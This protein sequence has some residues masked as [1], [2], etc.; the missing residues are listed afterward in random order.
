MTAPAAFVET[1]DTDDAFPGQPP[2]P[3]TTA[4]FVILLAAV[5]AASIVLFSYLYLSVPTKQTLFMERLTTCSIRVPDDATLPQYAEAAAQE[6]VCMRSAR[7]DQAAWVGAALGGELALAYGLYLVW[8]AW[9]RR[10]RGLVTFDGCTEIEQHLAKLTKAAE[11]DPAPTWL[12]DPGS[13]LASGYVFGARRRYSVCLRAGLITRFV[14]DRAAFDAVV[15]HELAHLRNRDVSKTHLT[16]TLWRTFVV[17]AALPVVALTIGSG[18]LTHP[19]EWFSGSATALPRIMAL[20]VLTAALLLIRNGIRRTRELEADATVGYFH[21]DSAGA[22]R[23]VFDQEPDRGRIRSW[24][25][26]HP[27]RAAR[28]AAVD[29]PKT[30]LQLR[31]WEGIGIGLSV[32]V[33]TANLGP[34]LTN[35]FSQTPLAAFFLEGLALGVL[36]CMVLA[37]AVWREMF[38]SPTRASRVRIL[39]VTP[40]AVS[41]GLA[42]GQ[43]LTA[44]GITGIDS[45]AD[46]VAAVAAWGVLLAGMV[47][48]AAWLY[49]AFR[50]TAEDG[51]S[52]FGWLLTLAAACVV[53][54]WF[55]AWL[56]VQKAESPA[57][58]WLLPDRD[59]LLRNETGWYR[60]LAA[61]GHAANFPVSVASNGLFILLGSTL[62]W[63]IPFLLHLRSG[64]RFA[65]FGLAL[66]TGAAGG[67]AVLMIG[68][69]LPIAAKSA[70]PLETRASSFG[71]VQDASYISVAVLMHVVVAAVVAG[72]ASRSRPIL[73]AV[74]ASALS[75][76]SLLGMLAMWAVGN[77]INVTGKASCRFPRTTFSELARNLHTIELRGML[78]AAIGCLIGVAIARLFRRGSVPVLASAPEKMS[79]RGAPLRTVASDVV[80]LSF[81]VLL[82]AMSATASVT[83]LADSF[84]FWFTGG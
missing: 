22:L 63:V 3:Q 70:L 7:L 54:G 36:V 56:L 17:V 72:A 75:A 26:P 31:P 5:S 74:S 61:W 69:L 24:F 59:D 53:T 11:I 58:W 51:R 27:G 67:V 79:W 62:F 4:R 49:S 21:P 13:R 71:W 42:V 76:V 10:R 81:V 65:G 18:G 37:I 47:C 46:M 9:I 39:L 52:A 38:S 14:K 84:G 34:N 66:R 16:L 20:L 44:V 50:L 29:K 32:G 60:W 30:L 28:R 40:F 8:P 55:T 2:T 73:V 23:A 43:L 48:L 68:C 25:G 41:S 77:C 78:L 12:L 15:L 35:L 19:A 33:V 45:S 83:R 64:R 1:P 57:L 82:I 6:A 80:A